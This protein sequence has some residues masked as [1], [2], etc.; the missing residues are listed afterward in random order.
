MPLSSEA[1][2]ETL[3]SNINILNAYFDSYFDSSEV[4]RDKLE[5]LFT[6]AGEI[7]S[8]SNKSLS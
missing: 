5:S 8:N 6:E 1:T 3:S 4:V 7:L 2:E